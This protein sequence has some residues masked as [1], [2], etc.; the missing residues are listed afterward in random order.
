M[1]SSAY[2]FV[3]PRTTCPSV[4]TQTY[5]GL[6]SPILIINQED[7]LVEEAAFSLMYTIGI[8]IKYGLGI[9][10]WDSIHNLCSI[11]VPYMSVSR[12]VPNCSYHYGYVVY[13]R[14][15][16]VIL[17]DISLVLRTSLPFMFPFLGFL[18]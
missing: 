15:G 3:Q 1:P 2:F 8:L 12:V 6:R 16:I 5:S 4:A 7:A 13:L 10:V 11:S 9:A 14:S 17:P 18:F